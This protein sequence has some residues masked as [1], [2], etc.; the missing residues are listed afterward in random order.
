[1][2]K[3][4]KRIP[5]GSSRPIPRHEWCPVREIQGSDT[6]VLRHPLMERAFQEILKQHRP[7]HRIAYL[8]LCTT[9]RPYSIGKKWSTLRRIFG[10]HVDLIVAS[11]GGII[12]LEFEAC[13]PFLNYDAHGEAKYDAEYVDVLV[14]RM[15]EFFS[16]HPYQYVVFNFRP[17]LRNV[18]A[19]RI[20]GPWLVE[21]GL[22]KGYAILPTAEHYAQAQTEKFHLRGYKMFPELYPAMLNPVI[23]QVKAWTEEA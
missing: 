11:N 16:A 14:R 6:D 20:V 1:M 18:K 17:N 8:S 19:A 2:S 21:K 7:H 22:A 3:A 10:G 15:K 13:F 9:T 12:P 23:R 4:D 5:Q